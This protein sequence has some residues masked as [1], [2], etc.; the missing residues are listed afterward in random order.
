MVDSLRHRSSL[1]VTLIAVAFC[2][3]SAIAQ[4]EVEPNNSTQTATEISVGSPVTAALSGS[5]DVDYFEYSLGSSGTLT[6][7][8]EKLVSDY[9]RISFE[10]LS[11]SGQ[12]M[13]GGELYNGESTTKTIGIS[14]PGTYY[15]RVFQSFSTS[16]NDYRISTSF[17]SA[18]NGIEFEPNNSTQ[19][20]TEI[21]VGSPVT[22][23]LSGS[24][25]VDY[26]EYSLGSSGTLTV[27]VEKL[28][29]DYERISF[30]VLSSSGQVMSGGELYNGES[31]T[32]TIGISSPGTYYVRVFQ[33][34][35]TSTNDYRISTSFAYSDRYYLVTPSA[36]SNGS[37]S[38]SNP[39]D[40]QEG[41]SAQFTL[42]PNTGYQVAGVGG[43]CGG[44]LN[45]TTYTTNAV[46]SDCTVSASFELIPP[47]TTFTVTP[48]AGANGSINPSSPVDVQA[49]NSAQ[50]TL[51][52]NTGYQVAAV[53][54][55]CGGTLNGTTYTTNAVTSDCTVSASFEP[56]PP[57]TTFTVTPSAGAN[58]SI[59][60]SNPQTVEEGEDVNFT[61][62]PDDGFE[63]EVIGGS[64]AGQ[65]EQ[66]NYLVAN[67][68][69][70]CTVE[71]TFR[72]I[73]PPARCAGPE[74]CVPKVLS[75][76]PYLPET[77]TAEIDLVPTAPNDPMVLEY[78]AWC[79]SEDSLAYTQL[80]LAGTTET[81]E[82]VTA[83]ISLGSMGRA[84]YL[85]YVT[86]S[87]ESGSSEPPNAEYNN[88]P[89]FN[90]ITILGTEPFRESIQG[91][92]QLMYIG[93]LQ[94]AADR[95]G[96]AYWSRT[97]YNGASVDAIRS[98]FVPLEEFQSF[99]GDR[100]RGEFLTALYLIY[101]NREPDPEG[102]EYWNTGGG[103]GNPVDQLAQIFI[104]A[105]SEFDQVVLENKAV[106]A[107]YYSSLYDAYDREEVK[108]LLET[109]DATQAS[110][111]AVIGDFDNDSVIDYFDDDD[112]GDGVLD[113]NDAFPLDA[114]ESLD[115]DSDGVGNNADTDDDNDGVSDDEDVF[116]LDDNES[117]D[118]DGDGI[119]NNAD[120][121]DDGDGADDA[122]DAFP[123][124][125]SESL[126]T[127]GD[128]VGNNADTDDDN[129]G[130]LDQDDDLPLDASES[131]DTDGDGIGDNA[132]TDD[133]GDGVED[134]RDPEPLDAS[135][136]PPTAYFE[137]T[138]TV[139]RTPQLIDFFA[140][141]S[142][143]GN[144]DNTFADVSWDFGDGAEASGFEV[145][146]V[147]EE[148]GSWSV[149]LTV[150]ND[151]GLSDTS[152]VDITIE[153][154]EGP[155]TISGSI[156]LG[157]AQ[158]TDSDVNQFLSELV[159][160]DRFNSAQPIPNPSVT[161]GYINEPGLGPDY[162][163]TGLL[164]QSGDEFDVYRI[165]AIGGESVR[166]LLGD[167]SADLDIEIYDSDYELVGFSV[168]PSGSLE[169]LVVLPNAPGTYF[170]AVY[171]FSGASRYNLVVDMT[172]SSAMS[173]ASSAPEIFSGE[174][175][176]GFKEGY[177]DFSGSARK[178]RPL[179]SSP[180]GP[181]ARSRVQLFQFGNNLSEA[182]RSMPAASRA[183][184]TREAHGKVA[185]TK[186]LETQL[187]I[188]TLLQDPAVEFAEPN[189]QVHATG[190]SIPTDEFYQYQWHYD[191]ID[192]PEAWEKA[193]GEVQS[194]VAVLDTG[195]SDHPDLDAVLT[196]DGYDF[197]N[198]SISG[199][200]D[201]IDSDPTDPGD[202]GA[203][204]PLC[205]T[206]SPDERSGFHGTHVA[207]TVA[208]AHNGEGV[209]GVT[210][211]SKV[212]DVRVLGCGGGS[213]YDI[214]QGILYAAGLPN[215]SGTVPERRADVINLSLGSSTPSQFQQSAISDAIAEG[216][217]V[218]AAA[219]N[220]GND[221]FFYPASFPNVISVAA[222]DLN[223][224]R[225]PYSTFNS[226][227]DI[228]AP[229]GDFARDDNGDG[230]GDAVVS[231]VTRVEDGDVLHRYGF[232]QGTS[233]AAPHVSGVL[234]LMRYGELSPATVNDLLVSGALTVDI[235]APGRDDEF[236]FGL[237]SASKAI[238]A[239]LELGGNVIPDNPFPSVTTESLNFGQV[240][241][242]L[243]FELFNGGNG[244]LLVESVSSSSSV[245][246]II[247]PNSADGLGQYIVQIDRAGLAEGT[248][249]HTINITT[250]SQSRPSVIISVMFEVQAV[251]LT[252]DAGVMWIN[253]YEVLTET[254][255]WYYWVGAFDAAYDFY[256]DDL[257]AGIYTVYGGTDPDNSG[258]IGE[259]TEA[260]GVYPNTEEPIY[261]IGNG[262]FYGISFA[263][264]YELP[265]N[266]ST[267]TAAARELKCKI[268]LNKE[269]LHKGSSAFAC[270]TLKRVGGTPQPMK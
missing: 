143:A 126:D 142:V 269:E 120:A 181:V 10:V 262:D 215:D 4:D 176:V 207:G 157:G 11:S 92:I 130:V 263:A 91:K 107:S 198:G 216:V 87:N 3:A 53:G 39:I 240:T 73:P 79:A 44:T 236:G 137:A 114:L 61:I 139:G 27:T 211:Y 133:D 239:G 146:H 177:S 2:A 247:S 149:V 156:V 144:A 268:P 162:T 196:G 75:I 105:A 173:L 113:V 108:S 47:P 250:N 145:S 124:D 260:W 68:A 59:S 259:E 26:F 165:N 233:M 267:A 189:I 119:G 270:R 7:T 14:S 33:S 70:D 58:G 141:G 197:V 74:P 31:T 171:P 153:P 266:A 194:I 220:E 101:F 63:I 89:S 48:S 94:R 222:T 38:P 78:S 69:A 43:S 229:G 174:A 112:D 224:N 127:D 245:I 22:A 93:L 37:I 20:A 223:A 56:I 179:D 60:P 217:I 90:H 219:G 98:S 62:V 168:N 85:C 210:K 253:L 41:N 100:T 34:F 209:V 103:S 265:L 42:S 128:G 150:T 237:L 227:V 204:N 187:L 158:F 138:T 155:I 30:E 21:S 225:A 232:K 104:D 118:T 54:G 166:L 19:T 52:P 116:P 190:I 140:D 77:Q 258:Y 180:A 242:Q 203:D 13:S 88:A 106:V 125:A 65:L 111:D 184:K 83:E 218:V 231:T 81:S 18:L 230:Y 99:W 64:C 188:K 212:M 264:P 185:L 202:G 241:P 169:E 256:V 23:A 238:D 208:A 257:P 24:S 248:Y 71:I 12:V 234:A 200:G 164:T 50:F 32:K 17:S 199:D 102:F 254:S 35:S 201:G 5:S 214:V 51:N 6:V 246:S 161:S 16:T 147:F 178:L 175:I 109:I 191:S 55:S 182:V 136:T 213:N 95:T 159:S 243:S 221:D 40:V 249:R 57:P 183:L 97:F 86:G 261:L 195:I 205:A 252:A 80:P 154:F 122:A 96:L 192:L 76:G 131:V 163:G 123:L 170:V 134:G 251:E 148:A 228:A 226:Q 135:I 66:D 244:E 25:D 152:T 186:E 28:V 49:G 36:G 72:P 110:V 160:N 8:V 255:N 206:R 132:D 151:A 1:L 129:D 167:V 235:G 67:V 117:V 193:M 45:G 82:R 9:E 29:S 15:V 84:P 46:T 172:S 121:D 115:T